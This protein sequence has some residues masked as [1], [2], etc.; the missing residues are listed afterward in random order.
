MCD[1]VNCSSNCPPSSPPNNNSLPSR[2]RYHRGR[3]ARIYRE[4]RGHETLAKTL[5]RH[6]FV[7]KLYL[8]RNAV[9]WMRCAKKITCRFLKGTI[10]YT[11][12]VIR[13]R[14]YRNAMIQFR[15]KSFSGKGLERISSD[16]LHLAVHASNFEINY[17]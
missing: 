15:Y 12:F 13:G 17:R 3:Y 5:T 7:F 1:R 2:L 14:N 8:N 10:F 16:P 4:K 9:A 6:T 11:S